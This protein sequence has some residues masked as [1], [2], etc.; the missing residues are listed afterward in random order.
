MR[1]GLLKKPCRNKEKVRVV[2]GKG[3]RPTSKGGNKHPP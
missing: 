1:A 2:M 3:S